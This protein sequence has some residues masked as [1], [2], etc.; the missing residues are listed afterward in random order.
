MGC[1]SLMATQPQSPFYKDTGHFVCLS[2]LHSQLVSGSPSMSPWS[3]ARNLS[4]ICLLHFSLFAAVPST[5]PN[6]TASSCKRAILASDSENACLCV[7]CWLHMCCCCKWWL[8]PC[9]DGKSVV[10]TSP[11]SCLRVLA[12]VTWGSM[13]C[14]CR[15]DWGHSDRDN[16]VQ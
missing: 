6:T 3:I 4:A 5:R 11:F 1:S 2:F 9:E 10:S 12:E 16:V 13:R 14:G 7:W 15:L 8:R